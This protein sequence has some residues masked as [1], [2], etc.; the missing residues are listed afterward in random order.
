M[1]HYMSEKQWNEKESL[2]AYFKEGLWKSTK[3]SGQ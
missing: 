3:L 2:M 1:T